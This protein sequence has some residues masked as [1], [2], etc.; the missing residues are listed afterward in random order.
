MHYDVTD[1]ELRRKIAREDTQLRA[2]PVQKF[3]VQLN[4]YYHPFLHMPSYFSCHMSLLLCCIWV[5]YGRRKA[6]QD[7]VVLLYLSFADDVTSNTSSRNFGRE[8]KL[9][10]DTY[11]HM[12]H[13]LCLHRVLVTRF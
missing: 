12:E 6:V 4:H 7:N 2:Q 13:T 1:Y 3:N 9:R 11:H 8:H 5:G 10:I